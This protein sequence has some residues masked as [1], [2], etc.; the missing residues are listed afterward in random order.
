MDLAA[1]D[2]PGRLHPGAA[3][4]RAGLRP[5]AGRHRQD[6][7][8]GGGGGV[9]AHHRPSRP[10]HPVT[11]GARG[12]RAAGLPSGRLA[13][14][15][16]PVSDAAL[17][18]V[19][20]HAAGGTGRAT[21]RQW[22]NRGGAVGVHARPDPVQRLR[23][24]GRGAKHHDRPDE[25]VLNPSRREFSHGGHRGP[26]PDRLAARYPL[27]L[28]RCPRRA[29]RRRGRETGQVHR[30]RRGPPSA[31]HPRGPRLPGGGVP[32]T[33]PT[34]APGRRPRRP[35]ELRTDDAGAGSHRCRRRL[36]RLAARV[37]GGGAAGRRRGVGIGA[38]AG[39]PGRAGAW[40]SA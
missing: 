8:G 34:T 9:D 27:R 35:C 16:R 2:E 22:R 24:P 26:E 12:R 28:A 5:G 36:P 23:H 38:A 7:S 33:G 1:L 31:G 30:R 37:A 32:E 6:L 40:S 25:D 3:Q 20:R 13:R 14:Q 19:V 21:S 17:R 10:H 11:A 4:F 18:C 39:G 29:R 15:G